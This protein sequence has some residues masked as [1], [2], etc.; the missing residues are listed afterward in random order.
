[1]GAETELKLHISPFDARRVA[2]LGLLRGIKPITQQLENV[3]Y[4][5]PDHALAAE[6][7]ALRHRRIGDTWLITIKGSKVSKGGLSTRAEWEYPCE[8]HVLDFSGIDKKSVRDYLESLRPRLV[9]LFATNFRRRAWMF[10]PHKD[11]A[12]EIALDEGEIVA[13]P[14]GT[15]EDRPLKRPICEMELE[16]KDGAPLALFEIALNLA[17]KL[18]LLPENESKAQRGQRL[19][20][21]IADSPKAAVPTSL[22][23]DQPPI[24]AFLDLANDCLNHFLANADGVRTSDDPEYIHQARVALRRLRALI[25]I[26]KPILPSDFVSTYISGW[27]HFSNQLGDARDHDVL[28]EE[29]LPSITC[30]YEGHDAIES[31]VNYAQAQRLRAHE[32]ARASFYSAA[33]GQLT[34]RFLYDLM[35]LEETSTP[36]SLVRFAKR[37]LKKRLTRIRRDVVSLDQVS[38]DEWHRLRIQFKRLR[39]GVDFFSS[40]YPQSANQVYLVELKLIQ[41]ALGK[42]NDLERALSIEAL[43]PNATRC[44]LVAGWLS[45]TQQE[46][47]GRF[48]E[49]AHRFTS[50]AAPWETN[51]TKKRPQ[52]R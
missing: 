20:R 19:F 32:T 50:L 33:L 9:P 44:E 46:L 16:L 7:I 51:K 45:A 28:V 12:I 41:D 39:Y 25:Q 49:I 36:P 22:P 14:P 11:L 4:D 23:V 6:R 5:T 18:S 15:A 27:R 21:G 38:I 40:L 2:R 42:I 48:P 30:H 24:E 43:A 26:F 13:Q 29:T 31:F 37:S 1:M 17:G 3:Y 10:A 47:M 52:K 35:R 34:L 8:P